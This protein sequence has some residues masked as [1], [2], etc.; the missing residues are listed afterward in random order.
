MEPKRDEVGIRLDGDLQD[1][2]AV[3]ASREVLTV[4]E[5]ISA[6]LYVGLKFAERQRTGPNGSLRRSC[7]LAAGSGN[8]HEGRGHLTGDDGR[9]AA[10]PGF[11]GGLPL[12]AVVVARVGGGRVGDADGSRGRLPQG[13]R[14]DRQGDAELL[15]AGGVRASQVVEREVV[16]RALHDP[17]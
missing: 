12:G 3:Y 8:G 5:A 11:R 15:Q 9:N 4:G 10:R 16:L 13:G 2:V 17:Q 6:L 1:R 14:D 7:D